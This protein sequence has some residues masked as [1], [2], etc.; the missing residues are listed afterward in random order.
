[1]PYSLAREL[2]SLISLEDLLD[3]NGKTL[4]ESLYT[5]AASRVRVTFHENTY[6]LCQ[7]MTATQQR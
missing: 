5:K 3:A 6:W 4:F 7:L 2:R 1:V